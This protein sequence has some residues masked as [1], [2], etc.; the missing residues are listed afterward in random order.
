MHVK[1]WELMGRKF[2]VAKHVFHC[3]GNVAMTMI[4]LKIQTNNKQTYNKKLQKKESTNHTVMKQPSYISM[5][6]YQRYQFSAWKSYAVNNTLIFCN[7]AM[8]VTGWKEKQE[9]VNKHMRHIFRVLIGLFNNTWRSKKYMKNKVDMAVCICYTVMTHWKSCGSYILTKGY[10]FQW[11]M[12]L[13]RR[14]HTQTE[15]CFLHT[16]M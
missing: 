1:V 11:Y 3:T 5:R 14:V 2:N 6:I 4:D 12:E 16:I 7:I 9:S 13:A 15:Y 10:T 8:H